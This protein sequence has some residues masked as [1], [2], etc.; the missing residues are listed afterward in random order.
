MR[1][2]IPQFRVHEPFQDITMTKKYASNSFG[3]EGNSLECWSQDIQQSQPCPRARTAGEERYKSREMPLNL[4]ASPSPVKY[5]LLILKYSLVLWFYLLHRIWSLVFSYN[6]GLCLRIF[7]SCEVPVIDFKVFLSSLVLLLHR[8]WSLA[9]SYN[10]GLCRSSLHL[11]VEQWT[12]LT[13]KVMWYQVGTQATWK[14]EKVMASGEHS[15]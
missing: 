13:G 15:G 9:F 14:E 4:C 11:S 10:I 6:I 8:I 5:L 1:V 3:K 12:N 2:W 7:F